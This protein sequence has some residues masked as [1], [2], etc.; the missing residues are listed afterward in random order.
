[1]A[2]KQQENISSKVVAVFL[3]V[4]AILFVGGVWLLGSAGRRDGVI[5]IQGEVSE[6]FEDCQRHRV[7]EDGEVVERPGI[8]CDGGSYIIVDNEQIYTASGNVPSDQ[9]FY[10]DTSDIAPG[11]L[12]EA[13][14][15]E[16]EYSKT[17]NCDS[18]GITVL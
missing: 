10:A 15:I 17:I 6:V 1:M 18:C 8:S 12:L 4:S 9:Y 2:E 16:G 7:L 3:I 5:T 11:D 13:R 14:F